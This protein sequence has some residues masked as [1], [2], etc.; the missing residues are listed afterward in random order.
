MNNNGGNIF[1]FIG[2]KKLMENSLE[3]FTTPHQVNIKSLVEAYGLDYL[4]CKK[5]EDLST[6]INSLLN[7]P[8]ATVLE[9]FT[10]A[11]LNTEN[12]SGYFRNIR[13]KISI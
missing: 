7:A 1:R 4:T 2:D 13:I 3:F 10:D 5:T 9:V 12:Y 8:K 6:S 11:D